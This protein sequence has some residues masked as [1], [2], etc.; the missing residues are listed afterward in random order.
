MWALSSVPVRWHRRLRVTTATESTTNGATVSVVGGF[1]AGVLGGRPSSLSRGSVG[2]AGGE[3]RYSPLEGATL[4]V[5]DAGVAGPRLVVSPPLDSSKSAK[6]VPLRM[7]K[8]VRA[9]KGGLMGLGVSRSGIEMINAA[10]EELLRLDILKKQLRRTLD[11]AGETTEEEEWENAEAA[12]ANEEEVEDAEESTRNDIV[13]QL[14]ILIEW[15]RRRQ[16]VVRSGRDDETEE[17]YVDEYDEDDD[18]TTP[19][20][21]TRGSRAKGAIAEKAQKLKHY[22]QREIE[23]KKM[24]KKREERKAKYVSEAGGLKY[25]AIAM[26]NR[27]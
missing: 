22:A 23:M 14:L 16:A 1:L 25:T 7:I 3:M 17:D 27:S 6:H 10:G 12:A 11:G 20:S 13:D 18:G 21:P 26:A 4:S 24:K 19:S 8:T 9:R 15:E 5:V 2:D